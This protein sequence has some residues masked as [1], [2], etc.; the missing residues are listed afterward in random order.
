[1]KPHILVMNRWPQ[2]RNG[3]QWDHELCRYEDI[4]PGHC[5]VS[6]LCDEEG[7]TGLSG[8]IDPR[9]VSVIPD[10]GEIDSVVAR[11]GRV[12]DEHGPITHLLAFSEYLLDPAA[13]VRQQF[14]IPGHRPADVDRFRDKIVMKRLL[15][16]ANMRV[17]KWFSCDGN[18]DIERCALELGFPLILKP[19]RGASSEGVQKVESLDALRGILATRDLKGFEIEEYVEGDIFHVDGVIDAEGQFVFSSVSRYI[20]SCLNFKSGSPLGSI[21]QTE[22]PLRSACQSFANG[23]LQAL[24][25]LASAF[26]L[27]LFHRDDEL[28]F[29]E[30][31]ARVPGADVP[32]VV[33][34]T[35]GVNLFRLWA[36]VVLGRS[37]SAP[38]VTAS[39]SGGWITI[40]RPVPLPRK[41][42]SAKSLLGSIPGLYR[43]LIPVPGEILTDTG[44]GY[45]HMQG[46]R[47]LIEGVNEADVQ[48]SIDAVRTRYMLE[49]I[50]A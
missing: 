31:G 42:L 3:R 25:L 21:I 22:S 43:E 33:H 45:T 1:M 50:P 38:A 18:E 24:G 12:I 7:C 2:Y 29:L 10:F 19:V 8:L 27:E 11:V 36:D 6:Y 47:F 30:V 13:A 37:A 15:G 41:V 23:C 16:A 17:P 44:G 14:G 28:I 40:P 26:H 32:Y 9:R 20:S 35:F 39:A 49:T 46:G 5:D 34:R 4:L 48:A